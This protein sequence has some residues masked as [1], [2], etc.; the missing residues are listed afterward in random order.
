MINRIATCLCHPSRIGLYYKD[1]LWT[2]ILYVV[3]FI[4]ALIGVVLM[5]HVNESYFT[6]DDTRYVSRLVSDYKHPINLEF[7]NRKLTGDS[8]I[9]ES[10]Y[11]DLYFLDPLASPKAQD[12]ISLYFN[13][14]SVNIYQGT[15]K[16]NSYS[17]ASSMVRDFNLNDIRT[18]ANGAKLEFERLVL[19]TLASVNSYYVYTDAAYTIAGLI[20][21]YFMVLLFVGVFSYFTNQD[22][23][24]KVRMKICL[25]CTLI[26][27]LM[28]ILSVCYRI[29]FFEII[30]LAL[31]LFYCRS[32]FSR[33]V[34]VRVNKV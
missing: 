3:V 19:A 16:L 15:Q 28:A 11:V 26:Y 5:S 6:M 27:P 21:S 29:S 32:A 18:G 20:A 12:K 8:I 2:P 24:M 1:K 9:I 33:I 14:E 25:Y 17:Y 34:R 7:N 30:G 10:K 31:P 22:L 4:L 13:E 23:T